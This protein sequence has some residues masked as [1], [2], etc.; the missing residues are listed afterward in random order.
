LYLNFILP[1]FDVDLTDVNNKDRL[2]SCLKS[3]APRMTH[4]DDVD[5]IIIVSRILHNLP[6]WRQQLEENQNTS[7]FSFAF[8]SSDPDRK[9]DSKNEIVSVTK[10]VLLYYFVYCQ[11]DKYLDECLK[12]LLPLD[13]D[14]P[15][16]GHQLYLFEWKSLDKVRQQFLLQLITL[17]LEHKNSEFIYRGLSSLQHTHG[18]LYYDQYRFLLPALVKLI[19]SDMIKI[20]L[21]K[22]SFKR[23]IDHDIPI[24]IEFMRLLSLFIPPES[25]REKTKWI[26]E[27]SSASDIKQPDDDVIPWCN[28][29]AS[30][31]NVMRYRGQR[32]VSET[33]HT[34]SSQH[35]PRLSR[36]IKID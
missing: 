16:L 36:H 15:F 14:K 17:H 5:K 23:C 9:P 35:N 1:I 25:N 4:F 31:S 18:Q 28:L 24:S 12:V 2:L 20:G 21:N 3:L 30:D 29:F 10:E 26:I 7:F 27:D 13:V 8:F 22:I 34:T 32:S 33:S 6:R 11:S 19:D